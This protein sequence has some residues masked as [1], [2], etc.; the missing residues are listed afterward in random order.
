MVIKEEESPDTRIMAVVHAALRRDLE[1][2][3][4]ELTTAPYPAATQRRALG[5]HVL[6][7]MDFLHRH[8]ANEDAG[9]WPLVRRRDP[10]VTALLDSL[11]ADHRRIAPRIGDLEAAAA[12]YKE[13]SD[14]GARL[15]LVEALEALT[16]VLVPHLDREVDEAMPVVARTITARE[17]HEWDQRYNVKGNSPRRLGLMGHFL[18]DGADEETR[19]LVVGLVPPVPRF[20]LLHGFA[21]TYRRAA[22]ARWRA[23]TA[24]RTATTVVRPG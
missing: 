10:A 1:R 3:R 12:S 21:R 4:R 19:R 22:A 9:L 18:I 7:L 8:H 13:S 5:E 14:D 2:A 23:E 6:W 24:A 17:W 15:R 20:V 11:E 16:N